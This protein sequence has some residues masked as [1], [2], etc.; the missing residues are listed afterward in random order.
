M[1]KIY[2]WKQNSLYC[3]RIFFLVYALHIDCTKENFVCVC[4][5]F[6]YFD[7]KLGFSGN[8]LT[9]EA[10]SVLC[11]LLCSGNFN[12]LETRV[13]MANS[14][15]LFV[16]SIVTWI[17]FFKMLKKYFLGTTCIVICQCS[18][19]NPRNSVV[20]TAKGLTEKTKCNYRDG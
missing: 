9:F 4:V 20:P 1:N 13:L 12:P 17:H 14:I 19:H 15:Q 5:L 3:I 6:L 10:L 18:K 11:I 8:H 2:E 16:H 7:R